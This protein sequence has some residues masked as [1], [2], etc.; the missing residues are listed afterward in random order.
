MIHL[1]RVP[2]LFPGP[3]LA[4]AHAE[5]SDRKPA[6][7]RTLVNPARPAAATR[8]EGERTE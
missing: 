1:S 6:T 3:L 4:F 7:G 2:V 8:R 5:V